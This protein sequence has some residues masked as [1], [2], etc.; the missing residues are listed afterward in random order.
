M[1][2]KSKY[3]FFSL[4]A[5]LGLCLFQS[6]VDDKLEEPS[7]DAD[8]VMSDPDGIVL[9]FA[10]SLN[11]L[12]TSRASAV[13][14]ETIID[15]Y[16]NK[17]D[18]ATFKVL[19]F[20]EA[21]DFLFDAKN[22]IITETPDQNSQ[23]YIRIP[24][25]NSI[26]DS[27]GKSILG[28]VR[29]ALENDGF[30]IAVLANWPAN[31]VSWG[32]NQSALNSQASDKKTIN[33][34]HY[35]EEDSV[36]GKSDEKKSNNV[37]TI[38]AKRDVYN[39]LNP[40]FKFGVSQDWVKYSEIGKEADSDPYIREN[41]NPGSEAASIGSFKN[42]V[43]PNRYTKL[44]Q[45]WNFGGSYSDS[46]SYSLIAK[47]KDD[48][49]YLKN[50]LGS[51]WN[52]RSGDAFE[53]WLGMDSKTKELTTDFEVDGFFFNAY[54]EGKPQFGTTVIKENGIISTSFHNGKYHGIKLGKTNYT[55]Q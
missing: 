21:G 12:Q 54:S 41:W 10:V 5:L 55:E 38:P 40:D 52:L 42:G 29:R 43:F 16:D 25:N 7:S 23:W 24:L 50:N 14:E 20:S 44:W 27:N 18:T 35:L 30:K 39:F 15:E 13:G 47:D 3:I 53:T 48:K 32:W 31:K 22:R 51:V 4:L 46:L 33:D 28:A 19:V 11:Q 8:I 37:V 45:V 1:Y 6:C 34:L 9:T 49:E 36:Y 17:V 26:T 2:R